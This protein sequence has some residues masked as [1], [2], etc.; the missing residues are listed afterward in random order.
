MEL[1]T[2][3]AKYPREYEIQRAI[4][5]HE[6]LL[7]Y[8]GTDRVLVERL[9]KDVSELQVEFRQLLKEHNANHNRKKEWQSP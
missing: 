4:K 9:V 2:A 6:T 8:S 7:D 5:G 1:R 3:F